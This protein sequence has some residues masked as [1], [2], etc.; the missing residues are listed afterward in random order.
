MLGLVTYD[1][2]YVHT[3]PRT[4]QLAIESPLPSERSPDVSHQLSPESANR[5]RSRTSTEARNNDLRI[6][7]GHTCSPHPHRSFLVP[8]EDLS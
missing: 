8:P 2:S 3:L 5:V 7:P 4:S 1:A 6:P